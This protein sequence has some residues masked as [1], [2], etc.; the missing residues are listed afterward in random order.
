MVKI[1]KVLNLLKYVFLHQIQHLIKIIG[2]L[3]MK[4]VMVLLLMIGYLHG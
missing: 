1:G 2:Q 3:C 4:L